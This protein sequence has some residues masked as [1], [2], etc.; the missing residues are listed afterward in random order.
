MKQLVR[1]RPLTA[2]LVIALGVLILLSGC[3][4]LGGNKGSRAPVYYDFDDIL[5]PKDMTLVKESTFVQRGP[6]TI[7]GVLTFKGRVEVNSLVTFFDVNMPKDNWTQVM[8][9]KS[10]RIIMVFKKANRSCVIRIEEKAWNTY[11]EI[12]VAPMVADTGSGLLKPAS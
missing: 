12:W 4:S 6:Q 10:E 8:Y 1:H 5:V 7:A 11:A 3:S 9:F 2:A